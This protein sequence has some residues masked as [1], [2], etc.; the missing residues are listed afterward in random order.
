MQGKLHHSHESIR[1][2][3]Y[4]TSHKL[5]IFHVQGPENGF[6]RKFLVTTLSRGAV[7]ITMIID[8]KKGS[9]SEIAK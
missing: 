2:L 4:R 3:F 6:F 8:N 7:E 5:E 1:T 9:G